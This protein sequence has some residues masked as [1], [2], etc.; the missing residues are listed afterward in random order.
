MSAE[1]LPEE[2]S[3]EVPPPD[4]LLPLDELSPDDELPPPD[5][6]PPEE[7][8]PEDE[9]PPD[10]E[11]P[12]EPLPDDEL[13][14]E[15]SPDV[16]PPEELLPD[17]E[18]PDELLPDDELPLEDVFPSS[19]DDSLCEPLDGVAVASFFLLSGSEV[20][21]CLTDVGHNDSR[22]FQSVLFRLQNMLSRCPQLLPASLPLI[23]HT[24]HSTTDDGT[25]SS[26]YS[27]DSLI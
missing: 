3:P 20:L 25:V 23:E 18:L 13:P 11:L 2:F 6:L 16:A 15:L 5:E 1:P 9:P 26:L 10:D 14:D 12:D 21:S 22:I 27:C 8:S 24:L 19:E 4:E 17:D 7:L